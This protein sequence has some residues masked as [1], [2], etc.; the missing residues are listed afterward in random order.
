MPLM[1]LYACLRVSTCGKHNWE[2]IGYIA[3]GNFNHMSDPIHSRLIAE[4]ADYWASW[5]S[6]GWTAV[7]VLQVKS[8]YAIVQRMDP[9]TNEVTTAE[10]RVRL[11]EMVKRIPELSGTDKPGTGPA[12]VFAKVRR[13]RDTD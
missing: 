7:K 6:K 10:A 9:L 8:K 4:G 1:H 2:A 5:G 3:K 13:A 12:D 11:D